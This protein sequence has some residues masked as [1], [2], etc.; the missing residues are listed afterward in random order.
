[1]ART[2]K[3]ASRQ[4][5]AVQRAIEIL[6]E[7]G[8]A[9]G[10]LGTNDLARRTGITAS[11]MSRVLATLVAGGL[12]EH[13]PSTGR[14][15]LGLGLIRLA[16]AARDGRDIRTMV[17]PHLTELAAR[18]GETATLSVPGDHEAVTVD[19]AQSARSVQSVAHLGRPSAAH[20]TAV[21]KVLLAYGGTLPA[22]PLTAYTARTI[23]DPAALSREA[24]E[25]LRRGWAQ[26]AGERE[27]GL[28]AVAVPV[29]DRSG[30]LAAVLGVQGPDSR[31]GDEPMRAAA[32]LL[33]KHA[34][35]L[36]A[37]SWS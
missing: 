18:T 7:L 29:L 16:D 8:E 1:V 30:H 35:Q 6:R 33:A 28:N 9:R 2:G 21:G 12:V 23:T 17:R 10:E 24:A 26:A 13:V 34:A 15:R 36:E 4:V 32:E 11:T 20:A 22:G 3:P 19:F 31:L 37:V 14:Y 25:V 27:E 5:E